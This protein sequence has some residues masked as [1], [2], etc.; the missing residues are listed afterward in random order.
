MANANTSSEWNA[1]P[2]QAITVNTESALTVPTVAQNY[3]VLPSPALPVLN[4]AGTANG[5]TLGIPPDIAGSVYDGHAFKVRLAGKAKTGTSATL[6]IK[7][8]EATAA[9]V[10]ATTAAA[11]S[12]GTSVVLSAAASGAIAT[13]TA[14]FLVEATFIWDS[15]SK[16]LNGYLNAAQVAGAAVA[17]NSG[18]VSTAVVTT[19]VASLGIT[20]LNFIP[21]FTFSSAN[22]GNSVTL[23]EFA[24]DRA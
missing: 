6:T 16:I 9:C 4:A 5:L 2:A 13:T 22:A 23:T 18:T 21:S 11:L 1:L 8:Y 15:T 3:G 17:V 20:D 19:P 14:N 7:L 24:I 12:T 10:A